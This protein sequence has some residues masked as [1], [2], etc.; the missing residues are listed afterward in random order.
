M[1]RL[2]R[3]TS[4][5]PSLSLLSA[6]VL[7]A[8]CP[9]SAA[10]DP[11]KIETMNV[12]PFGFA[13]ADG[14]PTGMW[15]EISEMVAVEAGLPHENVLTPY[16]RTAKDL[17]DGTASVVVRFSN[18]QL[19]QSSIPVATIVTL[20]TIVLGAKGSS[21]TQMADL[22]GKTI[23]ILRGG[24][25]NPAFSGDDLI[26]KFDANDYGQE[27]SMVMAQ[28]LDGAAGT[29]IGLYYSANKAGLTKDQLGEPIV[30]GSQDIVLLLS[31]KNADD[32]TVAALKAAVEKLKGEDA[33]TKV[34]NK[35]MGEFQWKVTDAKK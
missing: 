34:I 20:Q 19:E 22:H 24:T 21:F 11:L 7:L 16:A 2:F 31:K 18:S 4:T 23:G 13:G 26:K 25:Y 5:W 12:A 35:Y 9:G 3:F 33:F 6:A 14:K 1:K 29:A 17:E 8:G 32:K 10:A 30:L 27:L 15:Y 28:R